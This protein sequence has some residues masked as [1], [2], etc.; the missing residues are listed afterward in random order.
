MCG[1]FRTIATLRYLVPC[2]L[3]LDA[4]S[5]ERFGT[6]TDADQRSADCLPCFCYRYAQKLRSRPITS[7]SSA[8]SA[9][10]ASA[11]SLRNSLRNGGLF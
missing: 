10:N 1:L 9:R 3:Y 7:E 8:M 2:H 6:E 11:S 4:Q 5:N